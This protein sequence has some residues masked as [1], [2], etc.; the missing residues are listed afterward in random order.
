[1]VAARRVLAVLSG[2]ILLSSL[3]L[4]G[5]AALTSPQP[6]WFLLMF[7][8]VIACACVWGVRA[9]LGT[10][11]VL[12][13]S[14]VCVAICV[15]VGSTLGY[16]S[17]NGTVAGVGLKWHLLARWAAAGLL[18]LVAA[19]ETLRH[20]APR[21]LLRVALGIVLMVPVLVVAGL[22]YRGVG[23]AQIAALSGL[24]RVVGACVAFALSTALLAAGTHAIMQGFEG[25]LA[26]AR[27]GAARRDA[28][29]PGPI[30]PAG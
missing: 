15:F 23:S 16:V 12:A 28:A 25:A 6:A 13:I 3:G 1:M 17:V 19:A 24:W 18:A 10:E 14:L 2:L 26:A 30:S 11:T 8:I 9:C 29:A 21:S 20:D 5:V 4:A 27:Q 7:E 22:V